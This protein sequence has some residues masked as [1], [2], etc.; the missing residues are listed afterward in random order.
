MPR[1]FAER[2]E[3]LTPVVLTWL[4]TPTT[5]SSGDRE[6]NGGYPGCTERLDGRRDRRGLRPIT[7]R[8]PAH[9]RGK[10]AMLMG[11]RLLE[12]L[13]DPLAYRA[14]HRLGELGLS[15][16]AIGAKPEGDCLRGDSARQLEAPALQPPSTLAEHRLVVLERSA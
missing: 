8:Q 15:L 5:N 13:D 9:E 14:R 12:S 7:Q 2:C 10:L 16:Q 4:N 3:L 11:P 6:P 1:L